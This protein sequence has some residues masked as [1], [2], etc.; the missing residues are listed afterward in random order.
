V[1]SKDDPRKAFVAGR[2]SRYTVG[3]GAGLVHAEVGD[4]RVLVRR[5][6]TRRQKMIGPDTREIRSAAART[7]ELAHAKIH[8]EAPDRSATRDEDL[9]EGGIRVRDVW[10]KYL[11]AK[12]PGLPRDVLTWGKRRLREHYKAMTPELRSVVPALSSMYVVVQ[13]ARRMHRTGA[14]PLGAL[15]SG[16]E[17]GD[18]NSHPIQ[19]AAKGDSPTTSATDVGRWKTALRYCRTSWP[20]W[21]G[22]LGRPDEGLAAVSTAHIEPAEIDEEHAARLIAE[23]WAAGAWRAWA[24]AVIV[25]ESGRRIGAVG[26]YR[27]DIHMDA[28][29][30]TANDFG[31][32]DGALHVTWRGAP[33]KGHGYGRGDETVPCTRALAMVYHALTLNHPNPA[34]PEYPL[35]W[36]PEDPT[37][38]VSYEALTH[39]LDDAWVSAFGKPREKGIAWHAF[40]RGL[41][42]TLADLL[43][44]IAAG[45]Y[46]GRSPEVVLRHY[47]RRRAQ[48]QRAV[49]ETLDRARGRTG[50][51]GDPEA[52]A[53]AV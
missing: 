19:L 39:A 38:A 36:S 48:R 53:G 10:L 25:S 52:P 21:W 28:P 9:R 13:A 43:G 40:V 33:A 24:A 5:T 31:T 22:E 15:I 3:T 50:D 11:Q 27:P 32:I 8:R 20:Q 35:L 44:E 14:A 41:V 7:A 23:L 45:E 12:V 47:K 42:T 37:R 6:G 49:V 30:L 26:G 16:L 2:S 4:G 34:G 17:P 46:S 51:A 1:T 18:F 29:P